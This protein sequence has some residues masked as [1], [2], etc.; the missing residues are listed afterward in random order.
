MCG[1]NQGIHQKLLQ[2]MQYKLHQ[3]ILQNNFNLVDRYLSILTYYF[4]EDNTSMF[5]PSGALAQ[6]SANQNG[7][8]NACFSMSSKSVAL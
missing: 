6:M 1:N 2:S 5:P 8:K 4:L 7:A 3:F